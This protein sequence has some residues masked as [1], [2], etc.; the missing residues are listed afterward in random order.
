VDDEGNEVVEQD[1]V[2]NYEDEEGNEVEEHTIIVKKPHDA[3]NKSV[4]PVAG[5][6]PK[7][8]PYAKKV[9]HPNT[10]GRHR[11]LGKKKQKPQEI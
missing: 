7:V 5:K 4:K 9:A 11:P 10:G 8:V 1:W 2:R 6:K 3:D